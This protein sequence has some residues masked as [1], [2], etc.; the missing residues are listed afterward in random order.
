MSSEKKDPRKIKNKKNLDSSSSIQNDSNDYASLKEIILR[1]FAKTDFLPNLF[2]LD[3]WTW[4]L[5]V[6]REIYQSNPKLQQI[7]QKTDFV[8]LWKWE[9][10]KKSKIWQSGKKGKVGEKI[11]Y[12]DARMDIQSIDMIYDQSDKILIKARDEAHRFANSYRQ[13]QMSAPRKK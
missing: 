13:N 1:R 5:G 8:A 3:L 4:Q 12:F 9:A 2:I 6:V 7:F 11:Y 10:R